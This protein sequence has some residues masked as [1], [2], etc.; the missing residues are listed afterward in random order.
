MYLLK[1]F[2]TIKLI[3]SFQKLYNMYLKFTKICISNHIIDY[4]GEI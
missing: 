3:I 1:K 2:I 4:R